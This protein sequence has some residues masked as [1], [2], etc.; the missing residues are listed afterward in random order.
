MFTYPLDFYINS[1]VIIGNL[2]FLASDILLF[3]SRFK[4]EWKTQMYIIQ[5]PRKVNEKLKHKARM[6]SQPRLQKIRQ[7]RL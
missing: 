7:K 1:V 3:Y 5:S 4:D 2:H 6:K